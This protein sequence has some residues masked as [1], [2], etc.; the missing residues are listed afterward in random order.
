MI[1]K[2]GAPL[3][4]FY[5]EVR[6]P[7]SWWVGGPHLIDSLKKKNGGDFLMP[8]NEKIANFSVKIQNILTK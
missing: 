5:L 4:R 6:C 8:K 1:D 3:S 7:G 2:R